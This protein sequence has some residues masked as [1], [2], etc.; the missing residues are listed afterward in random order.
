M[1]YQIIVYYD[2]FEMI[3]KKIEDKYLNNSV[4]LKDLLNNLSLQYKMFDLDK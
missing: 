2:I 1:L 3:D 4:V